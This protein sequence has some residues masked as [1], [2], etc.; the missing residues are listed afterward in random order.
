MNKIPTTIKLLIYGISTLLFILLF[1]GILNPFRILDP[2][3]NL[4]GYI[5]GLSFH[6]LDFLAISSVPV[7]GM[8]LTSKRNN[9]KTTQLIKDIF[10]I[11]SCVIITVAIGFYLLTIIGKPSNPLVPQYIITQPFMLYFTIAVGIGILIPF[12]I[13]KWTK[14]QTEA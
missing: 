11:L 2:L 4:T 9:F 6:N 10:I 8:L 1:L 12:L 5:F 14:A 7:F 3:Q 13:R